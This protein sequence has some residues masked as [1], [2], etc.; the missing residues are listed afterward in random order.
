MH[1]LADRLTATVVEAKG[2]AGTVKAWGL[3]VLADLRGAR[4]WVSSTGAAALAEWP[5]RGGGRDRVGAEAAGSP[6]PSVREGSLRDPPRDGSVRWPHPGGPPAV[7]RRCPPPGRSCRSPEAA[8]ASQSPRWWCRTEVCVRDGSG[9][10]GTAGGGDLA[11]ASVESGRSRGVEVHDAHDVLA[12]DDRQGQGG[13]DTGGRCG[14][15]EQEPACLVD[16]RGAAAVRGHL[17]VRDRV[18]AWTAVQILEAVENARGLAGSRQREGELLFDQRETESHALGH[19]ALDVTAHLR[20]CGRHLGVTMAGE[21]L[22]GLERRGDRLQEA[23]SVAGPVMCFPATWSA[24]LGAPTT[25]Q[26]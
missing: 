18:L 11:V 4:R 14:A 5:T 7:P 13:R 8:T 23:S 25:P 24:N 21:F 26:T 10:P 6:R 9:C 20:Q 1:D 2:G 12:T 3:Q 15:G 19:Q 22:D 17:A 16:R